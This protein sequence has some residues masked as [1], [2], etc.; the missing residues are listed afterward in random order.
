MVSRRDI[1]R[2]VH[3]FVLRTASPGKV[4]GRR[5]WSFHRLYRDIRCRPSRR[6]ESV[7][8]DLIFVLLAV[9]FFVATW[10]FVIALKRL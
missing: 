7:M 8:S 3:L 5:P 6:E 9:A 2:I 10:F 4:L 1:R